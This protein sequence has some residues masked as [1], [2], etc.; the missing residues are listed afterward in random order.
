MVYNY[1]SEPD[2]I[3]HPIKRVFVNTTPTLTITDD[4]ACKVIDWS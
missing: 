2:M 4:P 1:F 3:C